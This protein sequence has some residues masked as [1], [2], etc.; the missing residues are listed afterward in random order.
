MYF[1]PPPVEA[2]LYVGP[3][4]A[5][6]AFGLGYGYC[7]LKRAAGVGYGA[8]VRLFEAF[9]VLPRGVHYGTGV[10]HHERVAPYAAAIGRR[11][12]ECGWRYFWT[13]CHGS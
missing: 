2:H 13:G 3:T 5:V 9:V 6:M 8:A 4:C 7:E 10:A 11:Q 1:P 12:Y